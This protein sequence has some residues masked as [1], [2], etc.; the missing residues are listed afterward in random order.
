MLGEADTPVVSDSMHNAKGRIPFKR[1]GGYFLDKPLF[2]VAKHGRRQICEKLKTL[3]PDEAVEFHELVIKCEQATV[4]TFSV[5]LN[6]LA[7]H[8][9]PSRATGLLARMRRAGVQPD[10]RF[11]NTLYGIIREEDRKLKRQKIPSV[12][13]ALALRDFVVSQGL[14]PC[15]HVQNVLLSKLS[16]T[17]RV[18]EAEELVAQMKEEAKLQNMPDASAEARW[19]ANVAPD[20]NTYRLLLQAL[21]PCGATVR[22]REVLEEMRTQGI[23][24]EREHYTLLLQALARKGD[25]DA[26]DELLQTEFIPQCKLDVRLF[27]PLLA[28]AGR[29][30]STDRLETYLRQ[31]KE[32]GLELDPQAYN[33]LLSAY[34]YLQRE[35]KANEVFETMARAN[36]SISPTTF[37]VLMSQTL[38]G[39]TGATALAYAQQ[40]VEEI[41]AEGKK[42]NTTIWNVALYT[43]GV[44]GNAATAELLVQEMQSRGNELNQVTNNM[45]IKANADSG[46]L[47]RA[48]YWLDER[49]ERWEANHYT[50]VPLVTAFCWAKDPER[51]EELFWQLASMAKE[52]ERG[53]VVL[54]PPLRENLIPNL[55]AK[56]V[57]VWGEVGDTERSVAC[58]RRLQSDGW[59]KQGHS[60][61]VMWALV[62]ALAVAGEVE[63]VEEWMAEARQ[64]KAVDAELYRKLLRGLCI[65]GEAEQA[66]NWLQCVEADQENS[67]MQGFE[68]LYNA[69]MNHFA[70]KGDIEKV[71]E[72]MKQMVEAGAHPNEATYNN[73]LWAWIRWG[74]YHS[75]AE[76]PDEMRRA[77]LE[78][79]DYTYALLLS[80]AGTSEEV[81]QLWQQML[82]AGI[83]PTAHVFKHRMVRLAELE[84]DPRMRWQAL[85]DEMREIGNLSKCTEV[86]NLQLS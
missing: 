8:N 39:K 45:M 70:Q 83:Q 68:P 73:L 84:P 86:F 25:L 27:T 78:P 42:P 37:S 62:E 11:Y 79:N 71:D 3:N 22:M 7:K 31:I 76:V 82:A 36:Y 23:V 60:N 34:L 21:C 59:L 56:L 1:F 58:V 30:G 65:A 15:V 2:E 53:Q 35:D 72:L 64:L 74:D 20:A 44:K 61:S 80:L 18:R 66:S 5:L 81:E 10:A 9:K 26:V 55:G 38:K 17:G 46:E 24:V 28:A 16:L 50:L 43:A 41:T 77:R 48:M 85:L 19:P 54:K 40:V 69:L 29:S 13:A 47:R 14:D 63:L 67:T 6:I 52:A 75:A 49:R 4:V 57:R 32:A 12:E 33:A 51:A